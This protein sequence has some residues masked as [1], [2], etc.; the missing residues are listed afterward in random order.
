[1]HK[2]LIATA[3]LAV[4]TAVVPQGVVAE[5]APQAAVTPEAAPVAASAEADLM[6]RKR[7]LVRRYFEVVNFDKTTDATNQAIA[8][9]MTQ[10]VPEPTVL[11]DNGWIIAKITVNNTRAEAL[12]DA[13]AEIR[14]KYMAK[15]ID[16]YADTFTEDELIQMVNFYESAVGRSIAA[17]QPGLAVKTYAVMT[18][19]QPEIQ[20]SISAKTCSK[21]FKVDSCSAKQ[22]KDVNKPAK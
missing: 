12:V 21:V 5:T 9:E 16:I 14:P 13:M 19:L 2:Y 7:A 11:P 1:M 15:F 10:D 3:I 6:T 4:L 18:A 17:K 22:K 8:D 20:A